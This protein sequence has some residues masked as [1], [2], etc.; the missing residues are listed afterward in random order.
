MRNPSP[1]LFTPEQV[2]PLITPNAPCTVGDITS[3]F[4]IQG[5]VVHCLFM[6]T[7]RLC[8]LLLSNQFLV[9]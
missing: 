3:D 5:E 8:F 4:F 2:K 9:A 1:F 6:H 7:R